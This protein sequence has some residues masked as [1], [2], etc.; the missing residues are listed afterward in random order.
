MYP[1]DSTL[2][3]EPEIPCTEGEAV[4]AAEEMFL[5]PMFEGYMVRVISSSTGDV[6][7]ERTK[8]SS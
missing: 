3:E 6:V 7:W 1:N 5:H 8:N 2:Y 4:S